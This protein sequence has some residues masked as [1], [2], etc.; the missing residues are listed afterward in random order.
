MAEEADT[1]KQQKTLYT[2]TFRVQRKVIHLRNQITIVNRGDGEERWV[3]LFCP[4]IHFYLIE[5]YLS[6][7]RFYLLTHY[8]LFYTFLLHVFSFIFGFFCFKI[9]YW[10][11]CFII[12]FNLSPSSQCRRLDFA[13]RPTNLN[14]NTDN[15]VAIAGKMVLCGQTKGRK[16]LLCDYYAIFGWKGNG[17]HCLRISNEIVDKQTEKIVFIFFFRRFSRELFWNFH[18]LLLSSQY[19]A[20]VIFVSLHQ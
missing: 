18:C 20:I 9:C 8:Y 17:N 6:F 15:Q 16:R 10:V 12:I 1:E 14:N 13:L 5:F 2:F 19:K 4:Y 7:Y 11:G 3:C